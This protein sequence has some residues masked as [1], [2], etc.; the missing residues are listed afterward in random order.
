MPQ[1]RNAIKERIKEFQIKFADPD[2]V[3]VQAT[4]QKALN[5]PHCLVVKQAAEL[6]EERLIYELE[7]ELLQAYQRFLKNPVKTDP[8]CTAKEAIARALVAL[9]SQEVDFFMAGLRYHQHE[10]VWGGTEDTAVGLRVS[11]AMGLVNTSYPRALIELVKLLYDPNSQ[12]RKGAVRAITYT[13]PLAAEAVLRSKALVGDSD[14]DVTGETLS[15]LLRV[16]PYE[17]QEFVASFLD[18]STD[19]MLRQAVALAIGA[20]KLDEA[21]D[22]LQSCWDN[23]PFKEEQDNVLLLGA[24]LHR[25]EKAFAWLLDVVV[26]GDRACTNFVIEELA[27]YRTDKKLAEKIESA[28]VEREDDVLTALLYETWR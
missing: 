7:A 6:C 18:S 17:S 21:L 4:V 19:P 12:A 9:D 25:S 15:A 8:N 13:Q 22:I 1:N 23:K 20:S 2:P 24:I 14:P 16:S 26:N 27:I 28:I 10:P 11:C 3:A 5:D